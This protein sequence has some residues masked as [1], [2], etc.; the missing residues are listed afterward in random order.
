MKAIILAAGQGKRLYPLTSD[1]PKVMVKIGEQRILDRQLDVFNK[2]GIHDISVIKG[3]KPESIKNE[4]IKHYMN[5]DYDST[6]MVYTLFCAQEELAGE[7]IIISY[8]DIVYTEEVLKQLISTKH[9]IS[10][11]VDMDWKSY[12]S[13]RFGDPYIDAES[14][15][16]G[17][18][19]VIRAIGETKPEQ[20]K[21][22][23]QYIGL[24]K[25]NMI[26]LDI[27]RKIYYKAKELDLAIGWGRDWRKAYMTDLLQE[28]ILQGNEIH[29][30]PI[31]GSWLEIDSIEDYQLANELILYKNFRRNK[32]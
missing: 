24:I 5:K 26:G 13:E 29:A 27:A 4:N 12:F 2:C 1:S 8:G 23:A 15:V 18:D 14:L 31:H 22:Q 10:V 19:N 7:D 28:I 17:K 21:I 9:D 11:A 25:F 32:A 16:L 20:L 30:E 3:Y 6:N